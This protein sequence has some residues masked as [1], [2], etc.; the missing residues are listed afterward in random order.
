MWIFYNV[1]GNGTSWVE[2]KWT[3]ADGC[4][5]GVLGDVGSDGDLDIL[6]ADYGGGAAQFWENK[7]NPVTSIAGR[8]FRNQSPEPRA[9]VYSG[10]LTVKGI[11]GISGLLPVID[12]SGRTVMRDCFQ[13][14][15]LMDQLPFSAGFRFI[16]AHDGKMVFPLLDVNP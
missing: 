5:Q 16:V 11:G 10:A 2:Q 12:V 13:S 4:W 1:N 6:T 7:L 15:D 3:S 8:P 14:I 9:Y